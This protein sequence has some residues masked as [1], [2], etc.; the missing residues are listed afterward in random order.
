MSNKSP[1][2]QSVRGEIRL[3]GYSIRTEKSYLYWIKRYIL[4]HQKKH[5][6]ELSPD[7]IKVFLSW[8][9]SERNMAANTQKVALNALVFLYQNILKQEVGDL[10]FTLATK[11]RQLPTVLS[12]TEVNAILQRLSGSNA[13]IIQLLYGSGLRI[14][15][16]LRLRVQDVDLTNLSLTIRDG[17]GNKDRQTI[18]SKHSANQLELFIEDAL[19]LQKQDNT[20]A[21]GPSLPFA[22]RNVP[23]I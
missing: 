5:P 2:L 22:L 18:L 15:E 3:R 1:F 8:L 7:H 4:F 17:K 9:S 11:Q 13:L 21:I 19:S 12:T 6:A 23:K 16:C 10:G 14:T 20:R